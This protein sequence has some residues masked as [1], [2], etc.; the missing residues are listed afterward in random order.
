MKYIVY[1]TTNIVNNYIYIG[2]HKT[3]NP[4][5][6]DGYLGCGVRINK[7]TTYEKGKTCFQQAVKQFGYKNFRRETLS[8]FDTVEEAYELEGLIVNENFLARPDV[9]N[10]ILGG[11]LN[12][13]KGRRVYQYNI[14]TGIFEKEYETC[15]KA[16]EYL[17]CSPQTISRGIL[18][19]YSVKGVILSYLKQDNIDITPYINKLES[20]KVYR[21]KN[22]GEYDGEF[23]SLSEAGKYSLDTTAEYIKKATT[24]GYLVKN[25]FYFSFYKDTSYDKARNKQILEREV[26]MYNSEGEFVKTYSSQREAEKD[27]PNC[28]ITNSIKSKKP[29]INGNLWALVRL[30]VYNKPIKKSAKKV[31][32]FDDKDNL[33]Q[34]WDSSNLCAKEVGTGVK[35]VLQNK[36]THHKG[37]IYK[38]I[39]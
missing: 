4:N 37:F 6:F 9:Y 11:Q 21:Y 25:S 32:K 28:N 8:I 30:K 1:K 38:Y 36:F 5:V 26:F 24:L 10:M 34:T 20:I 22:T 27:N 19:F 2:V 29:D 13:T 7:P 16:S 17:N 33:L 23:N 15:V 12:N 31:G 35:Q 3:L 14:K 39:D 18:N